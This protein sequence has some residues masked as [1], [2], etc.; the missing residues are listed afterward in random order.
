MLAQRGEIVSSNNEVNTPPPASVPKAKAQDPA[1]V[2]Q[3]R[4]AA[5]GTRKTAGKTEAASANYLGMTDEEF[6]KLADV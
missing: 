1:V 5:A 4:K 6:M 2:K 3:K